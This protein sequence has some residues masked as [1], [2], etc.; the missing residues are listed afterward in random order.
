MM[1]RFLPLLIVSISVAALRGG[2]VNLSP[3]PKKILELTTLERKQKELPPLKASALLFKV[4]QAHSENMA[5]QGKMEH[6]L[7]GMTP[8]Q[9]VR[10]AGY[11]YSRVYE[12]IGAGD[13]DVP[14]ED[15]MKAWMDSKGHRDNILTDVCTEIGLGI[16]KDKNG[17]VYYT[18]LFGK[19]K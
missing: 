9:R 13:A 6:K 7:D 19:P 16:A 12:N 3:A 5:K 10:A 17:Q 8:L 18:Q 1:S 15:L 4:A 14:L 2:E 11:S